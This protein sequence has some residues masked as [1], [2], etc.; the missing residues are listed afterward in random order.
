LYRN[1]ALVAGSALHLWCVSF[2]GLPPSPPSQAPYY[3]TSAAPQGD[4]GAAEHPVGITM[5]KKGH[6]GTYKIV[7]FVLASA[8]A[9]VF[10]AGV[11]GYLVLRW[12]G[13]TATIEPVLIASTKYSAHSG[14]LLW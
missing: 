13:S 2:V 9:A 4:G 3:N 14:M 10:C 6:R 1:K 8:M 5:K 11:L 7:I 12:R